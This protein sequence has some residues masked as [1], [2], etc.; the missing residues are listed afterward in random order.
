MTRVRSINGCTERRSI[1]G[2]IPDNRRKVVTGFNSNVKGVGRLKS[3]DR[4]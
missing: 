4:V 3:G 1:E 2:E